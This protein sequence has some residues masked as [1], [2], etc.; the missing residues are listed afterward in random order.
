MIYAQLNDE[1][2][3]IAVSNLSEEVNQHNMI[4]IT[5]GLDHLGQRYNEGVWED[6]IIPNVYSAPMTDAE[7][8]VYETQANVEYLV[9]M[10]ELRDE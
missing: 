5:D 1:N 3:C 8:A 9:T 6:V 10:S 4:L 2:I 7:A